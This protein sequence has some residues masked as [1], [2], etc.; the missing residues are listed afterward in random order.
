M[1]YLRKC[2]FAIQRK[3]VFLNVW[4]AR[5]QK[6]EYGKLKRFCDEHFLDEQL[7]DATLTYDENMSLLGGFTFGDEQ[8]PSEAKSMEAWYNSKSY[9]EAYGDIPEGTV[10]P[11]FQRCTIYYR[12][13][14]QQ[15]PFH[16]TKGQ[17]IEPHKIVYRTLLKL[18]PLVKF[19]M[20]VVPNPKCI[21]RIKANYITIIGTVEDVSKTTIVLEKYGIVRTVNRNHVYDSRVQYIAGWVL[22]PEHHEPHLVP[23]CGQ[24]QVR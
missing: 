17:D 8:S 10:P 14:R 21:E 6:L 15:E 13:R 5:V 4:G 7:I 1:K 24:F 2:R 3:P 16:R 11:Q 19:I 20:H 22:R 18:M 23:I 12:S 9:A